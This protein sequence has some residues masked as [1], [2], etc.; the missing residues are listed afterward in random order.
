MNQI[1]AHLPFVVVYLDDILIFSKS[2]EE[3]QAHLRTVL[4]IL[5]ENQFYAKLSKCSFYQ[6]STK[7]LGYVV[8]TEGIKMD[9]DK[10]RAVKDWPL[11][12]NATELRSFLGLCNHYKR[13]LKGYATKTAPLSELTHDGCPFNLKEN[14]AALESFEW[15][16]QVITTAPV[17]AV[18]DFEAR[19]YVVTDASGFGIGGVLMQDDASIPARR[20]LAFHSARLSDAERNYPVG[21]Q[22][23]LAVISAFR[24]W[25]CYLEG[26]KGGV[27]VITDHLPNTFLNS[28][29]PEQLSRRQ[30]R[31]QL[32]LS[33]I[34]PDWVYEK[35]ASNAAD[36]LSRCPE[37]LC[38]SALQQTDSCA[39]QYVPIPVSDSA[40]CRGNLQHQPDSPGLTNSLD[41]HSCEECDDGAAILL[42]VAGAS[43]PDD[44]AALE[45]D[46]AAWYKQDG[47]ELDMR[48]S[49]SYTF[50]K[51]LW[52][53]GELIIVPEDYEL[54]RRCIAM[55][56]DLP[57]A[58][59]PGRHIT[60]E[61]VQRQFWWPSGRRDVYRYVDTCTSC[62]FNKASTQK[63]AG[64]SKPLQIPDNPWQSMSMDLIIHLPKTVRGH[65]A[66][67]VFVDRL[68]KMVHLAPSFDTLSAAAFA[69]LF[70]SEIFRRHGLPESIVSD[71]DTRFTSEFGCEICRHLGIKQ[72]MSTAFHP[73]TDGQTERT[74]RTLEEMLRHY[75]SLSQDDWDL[76]LPCAE[77]AL[78][79]AIKAAT[80]STPFFLNHGRHPRAPAA[81]AMDTAVPAANEFVG[82]VNEAISRAKDCL[83]SAQA[84]MK[85]NA[86]LGRRDMEFSIGDE[87]LL[88]SKNMQIKSKGTRKL[89]P[90]FLGPFAVERR[91]GDLAYQL[92]I[93]PSLGKVHPVFHVSLLRLYTASPDQPL[94]PMPVLLDGEVEFEIER[95]LDHRDIKVSQLSKRKTREFLVKWANY[96]HESNSW[97]PAAD[98]QNCQDLIQEYFLWPDKQLYTLVQGGG[99]GGGGLNESKTY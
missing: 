53:Y 79:N 71:R 26:A 97:V 35:G 83:R 43:I 61:L 7:F 6:P 3:H 44:A 92:A 81:I 89:M 68:T 29:S 91:I 84:R 98:A 51:G 1:F 38:V 27:T 14:K 15:L 65:T 80:G 33:R 50:R 48:Q 96:V 88:S 41:L 8:D 60:L 34:D 16:Q 57:S 55:S 40:L 58:G 19:F 46:I 82:K 85:K 86:D 52:L 87:V 31:W 10:V 90:R 45:A 32:E 28:K 11:P 94:P 78:N 54:R 76:K 42:A 56:H 99:G 74:N 37:L 25:R 67:V 95:V 47:H 21:E 24:K 30:V 13:F 64:L 77:F 18:P 4:S 66:I 70:M 20:P 22:E 12:K 2:K 73:Q 17:L 62:Q 23:L 72:N 36:P 5:K 75:V 49:R 93:P 63:P 69:E 39:H 9:P 59:H